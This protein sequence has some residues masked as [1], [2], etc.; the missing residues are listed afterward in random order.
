MPQDRIRILVDGHVL[1]GFDQGSK[2]YLI[3]LW[4]ELKETDNIMLFIACADKNN[5]EA[6][7]TES[8]YVKFVSLPDRG[9][10][11]RLLIGLPLLSW[12]LAVDYL[13]STY[14]SPIF[15]FGK[16]IVSTHDVLFMD[17]P[18]LFPRSF[19]LMRSLFFRRSAKKSHVLIT[20]S[21][22]SKARISHHY[23][24]HENDIVVTPCGVSI[25][26]FVKDKELVCLK[27]K[28]FF[29]YVSRI[30]PRKNQISLIHALE[31]IDEEDINLVFVGKKA[32]DY[33][34]FIAALES[35]SATDRIHL[36]SVT[37]YELGWLYRNAEACFYPSLGEGFGIPPIE[38]VKLGSLT[39]VADNTA[40]SEL[41]PYVHGVF[42]AEKIDEIATF[43]RSVVE[44][45]QSTVL[46]MSLLITPV[47]N[48]GYL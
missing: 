47:T 48:G 2:T 46:E 3:G 20:I 18:N 9:S 39:F 7:F 31:R 23:A 1:D 29:L 44:S 8:N 16:T 13:H 15:S 38:S 25:S 14:I 40:L 19:S 22:Y 28:K 32:I 45:G 43:M 11:Y 33:P 42:A 24:I 35:S 37:N 34:E 26:R 36:M 12:N 4:G 5:F 41:R 30:E 21:E 10:I 17:F 27:G 6:Y